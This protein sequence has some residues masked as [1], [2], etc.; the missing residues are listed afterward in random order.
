MSA[1]FPVSERKYRPGDNEAKISLY[2]LSFTRGDKLSLAIAIII[3]ILLNLS[4]IYNSAI[5]GALVA[6]MAGASLL[7]P[8]GGFYFVAFTQNM[9]EVG[10]ALNPAQLGAVVWVLLILPRIHKQRF[11]GVAYL[12]L[13]LPLF[14]WQSIL[15]GQLVVNFSWPLGG[16]EKAIVWAVVAIQLANAAKGKYLQCLLGLSLGAISVSWSFWLSAIG[17]PVELSTFGSG[18]GGFE[19]VG[20][21][22]TDSVMVWVGTLLGLAGIL[23]I[24][25]TISRQRGRGAASKRLGRLSVAALALAFPPVI[26]SMTVTAYLGYGALLGLYLLQVFRSRFSWRLLA[27]F[28]MVCIV[29]AGLFASNQFGL[30]DRATSM[31]G[32]YS[33]KAEESV[34]STRTEVW[35]AAVATI[36]RYPLT[37]AARGER[38]ETS[39]SALDAVRQ[40]AGYLAHSVFLDIGKGSGIPGIVFYCLF[41]FYP[42]V[43]VRRKMSP[44][45]RVPFYF[46]YFV[47]TLFL[48]VLSFPFYK[49]VWGFLALTVVCAQDYRRQLPQRNTVSLRQAGS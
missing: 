15:S 39:L 2:D 40:G 33:Q 22:G 12:L 48:G 5:A 20:A 29:G 17:L 30:R 23:G 37:G 25:V 24:H 18:R 35:R 7:T 45:D 41:V 28:A 11:R 44:W 31:L 32:W 1:V 13:L 4:P 21:A 26:A 27:P 16:W 6:G 46:W 14:F 34:L 47:V 8:I 36:S 43:V 49:T 38:S 9:P 10:G 19:R 3:T 42:L